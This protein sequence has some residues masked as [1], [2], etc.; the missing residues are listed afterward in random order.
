MCIKEQMMLKLSINIIIYDDKTV[1][2]ICNMNMNTIL[3]YEG[4]ERKNL[5]ISLNISS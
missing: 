5:Y 2:H 1:H 4:I 3:K